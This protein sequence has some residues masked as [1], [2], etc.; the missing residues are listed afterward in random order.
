M[1]ADVSYIIHSARIAFNSYTTHYCCF[2]REGFVFATV[3]FSENFLLVKAGFN[4][5]FS[6]QDNAVLCVPQKKGKIRQ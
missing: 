6:L 2:A 1:G 5:R 3:K 4:I